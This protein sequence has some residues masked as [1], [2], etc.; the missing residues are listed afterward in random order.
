MANSVR[1]NL[2]CF[3]SYLPTGENGKQLQ[4]VCWGDGN[5][6]DGVTAAQDHLLNETANGKTE[7]L[8]PGLSHWHKRVLLFQ[9]TRKANL[10]SYNIK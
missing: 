7:E 5:T 4:V 8:V 6:A 1:V 10:K 3:I 9:V 2:F